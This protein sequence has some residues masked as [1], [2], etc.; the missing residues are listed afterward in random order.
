MGNLEH[1]L[2]EWLFERK[3]HVFMSLRLEL[4]WL[5]TQFLDHLLS[6]I[7]SRRFGELFNS[8]NLIG[9]RRFA[10]QSDR[11]WRSR[12]ER[13]ITPIDLI[14][15]VKPH[16]AKRSQS[17]CYV[18]ERERSGYKI[19]KGKTRKVDTDSKYIAVGE[20]C[21]CPT[22][23]KAPGVQDANVVG[24]SKATCGTIPWTSNMT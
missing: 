24:G 5:L 8:V 20:M 3:V 12:I 9:S 15:N 22:Q 13:A 6:L 11:M 14:L 18:R 16:S 4:R 7:G 23:T 1:T 10:D 2:G 19:L 21:F 17:S